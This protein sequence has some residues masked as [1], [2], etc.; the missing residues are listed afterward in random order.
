MAKPDVKIE[1]ET[2]SQSSIQSTLSPENPP[3][4]DEK[5]SPSG[6]MV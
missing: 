2:G 1:S 4:S 5:F 6:M 3:A